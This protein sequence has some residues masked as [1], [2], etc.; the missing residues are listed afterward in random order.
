MA[1][2]AVV[3]RGISNAKKVETYGGLMTPAMPDSQ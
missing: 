3:I 2:L 1:L